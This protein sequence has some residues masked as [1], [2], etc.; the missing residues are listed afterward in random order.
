MKIALDISVLYIARAGVFYYH[1]NLLRALLALPCAHEFVL[2]DYFP[3]KGGWARKDPREVKT[4]LATSPTAVCRVRGLK[5][6]KL[7]HV[8][9]VHKLRLVPLAR[10]VDKLLDG[11]WRKFIHLDMDRHLRQQ[12]AGADVFHASDVLNY[13]LPGAR[14]VTTILDLTAL[15]FPEYHT[16]RVQETLAQKFRL[17]QTKTQAVI[18][19]SE[20]ARRDAIEHLGLDPS[21][22][23]VVY[24]GVDGA[25]RPL[26][27]AT[28]AEALRPLGLAPQ[29]YI[30]YV[31]TIEPRK[32]LAR[33]VRA[34]HRVRQAFPAAPKLVLVGIKGW[35][36][37]DVLTAIDQL[38][39]EDDVLLPG[40]VPSELLPAL[41]N[42]AQLLAYPSIYEGFGLPA[43]EAMACGTPVITS[44]T[45]SLPE[46]VGDAGVMV[47]P[48][49]VT[50]L[51]TAMEQ[52]LNDEAQRA[53]FRQRGLERAAR[54][55]WEA[56]ARQTLEVYQGSE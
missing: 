40:R 53:V 17:A 10:R 39:L 24:C 37:E 55:T 51:A 56:T 8:G 13:A 30:L 18:A 46:V 6:R 47:D 31:G 2:L 21:R 14:N 26:P 41:Y 12:L 52:M 32:N 23:H 54:F 35:H 28:V 42:G 25:F 4:L 38:G 48:Y 33:L 7:A 15:L 34:Y 9:P 29:Q 3:V 22:V 20:C 16:A 27:P 43:L 49:D 45:S 50:Q 11:A 36:Y 1:Y 5:H 44:N 19:I